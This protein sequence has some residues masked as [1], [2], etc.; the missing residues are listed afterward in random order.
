M[1]RKLAA[2]WPPPEIARPPTE[3]LMITNERQKTTPAAGRGA[4]PRRAA[5][6]GM[7]DAKTFLRDDP[8]TLIPPRLRVLR[9]KARD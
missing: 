5:S 4:D 3:Y 7:P 2:A 8:V 6:R 1:S 9:Q